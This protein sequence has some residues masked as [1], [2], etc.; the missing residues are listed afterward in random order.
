MAPTDKSIRS[1]RA[2]PLFPGDGLKLLVR[3]RGGMDT[4]PPGGHAALLKLGEGA[5]L[6]V[7]LFF[8]QSLYSHWPE[9]TSF[10]GS[11]IRK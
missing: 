2:P 1:V 6:A 8:K 11:Q 3:G 9:K 7:P 5:R 10:P 4:P